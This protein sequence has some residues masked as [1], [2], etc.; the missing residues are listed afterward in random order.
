MQF[1][2]TLPKALVHRAAIAEAFLTDARRRNEDEVLLAGQ[3]PRFHAFYHDTLGPRDSH[4]PMLL[5]EACRQGIFV[6]AH[7]FLDVPLDHKFLLRAMEFEVLDATALVREDTPTNVVINV[8]IERRTRGRAG[9]VGL[10]L[11]FTSVIDGREA[12]TAGINYSWMP[13]EEWARLRTARRIELGLPVIPSALPV[14]RADPAR[15]DRRDPVNTVISP[16]RATAA[17]GR[18]ARLVA[19]T[20]HPAMFDHWL[21]HVPGMLELEAFRQLALTAAVDAGTLLSPSAAL[22]GLSARFR[23]FG[24]L[25]LPLECR[26][27]PVLPGADIQCTLH[28]CGSLVADAR[29]RLADRSP[30]HPAPGV[31]VSAGAGAEAVR[32]HG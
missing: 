1:T 7:R 25:D 19:D 12:M 22:V 30:A 26:T 23:C 14:Q 28:Q 8:R 27:A 13:P 3:L 20:S 32:T 24:E 4:D 16:S 31:G 15:V 21:D 10:L 9:V 6:V 11:R 18:T 2:R 17:G 5:L 29:I